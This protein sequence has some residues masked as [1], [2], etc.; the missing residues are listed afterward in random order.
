MTTNDQGEAIFT[1]VTAGEKQYTVSKDGYGD[2]SGDV[3][4]DSS[5]TVNVLLEKKPMIQVAGRIMQIDDPLPISVRAQN[6]GEVNLIEVVIQYDTEYFDASWFF[7]VRLSKWQPVFK[8]PGN[9]IIHIV[10]SPNEGATKLIDELTNI[11]SIELTPKKAGTT[12]LAYTSYTSEGGVPFETN[13]ITTEGTRLSGSD[14][15]LDEGTITI[16]N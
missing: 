1:G 13:I 12:E 3:N 15:I 2:V 7:S 8:D 14:L 5:K 10:L 4:V 16:T 6:L 11:L 9:G